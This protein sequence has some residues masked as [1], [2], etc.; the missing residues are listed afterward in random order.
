MKFRF[1]KLKNHTLN[2]NVFVFTDEDYLVHFTSVTPDHMRY[3][4]LNADESDA[5]K[6]TVWYS[7]PNRLDVFVDGDYVMATNARLTDGGQYVLDMP[8]G[9]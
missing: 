5:I 3:M 9:N 7:K 8:Q 6:L 4:I 2:G 1:L